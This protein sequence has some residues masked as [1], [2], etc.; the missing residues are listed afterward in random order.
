MG[1]IADLVVDLSFYNRRKANWFLPWMNH[2][3]M[4]LCMTG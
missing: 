3:F 4:P 2:R 1:S